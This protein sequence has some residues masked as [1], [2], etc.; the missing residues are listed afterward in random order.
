LSIYR[1]IQSLGKLK[2]GSTAEKY[3]SEWSVERATLGWECVAPGADLCRS[4]VLRLRQA[5]RDVK[6]RES[7]EKERKVCVGTK[8]GTEEI[9]KDRQK[10]YRLFTD[11]EGVP[12]YTASNGRMVSKY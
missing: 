9:T 12:E 3:L 4:F 7:L 1:D 10:L 11:N 8:E 2:R 5:A 6:E